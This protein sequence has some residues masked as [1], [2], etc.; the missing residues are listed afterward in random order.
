MRRLSGL[1]IAPEAYERFAAGGHQFLA[2]D[3]IAGPTL[4][5]ECVKRVPALSP[6][7]D[8]GALADYAAWVQRICASVEHAVDLM[9]SRGVIFNDLHVN[10]IIV[11]PG[12]SVAFIDFEAAGDAREKRRLTV[13]APGFVAPADRE[14][15][16]AD[17][18][19]L[20][21]LR[22]SLFIPLTTL[23]TLDPT[24]AAQLGAAIASVYPVP[25]SF[26]AEAVAEITRGAPAPPRDAASVASEFAEAASSQATIGQATATRQA[27]GIPR[28][29]HSGEGPVSL[30]DPADG[31][32]TPAWSRLSA[33][34]I[35]SIRAS[36][37]PERT[38]RLFPGDIGQF[39]TPGGGLGLAYGAAGVLYALDE[40]AGVR[41]PAYE[42]WLLR[43][44]KR[45]PERMPLGCWDG[46]SGIAWAL[47]RLGHRDEAVRLAEIC[48]AEKWEKLSHTL[49]GGIAGFGLA[50]LGVAEAAAEPSLASA[51]L[52]AAEIVA[53]AVL[54]ADESRTFVSPAGAPGNDS[55]SPDAERAGLMRGSAGKALLCVAAYEK[56]ADP[57]FLDAAVTAI[58]A[59][60]R[61][62][63]PDAHGGLQVNE[64]WRIMPYLADGSA[65]IG[66]VIDR[67]LAHRA[68]PELA[69]AAS[70]IEVAASFVFYAY[71]GLFAGRAGLLCFLAGRN[72]SSR[73]V[74]DHVTRLAWHAFPC[75]SGI[76]FPGDQLLRL[77]MDLGTG[78]AGVL[79]G[80]ASALAPGG[81]GVPFLARPQSLPDGNQ[82]HQTP[83]QGVGYNR[84]LV[85]R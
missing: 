13:G 47:G 72:A 52:R 21:C 56:T 60:L 42:E 43:R 36:A 25:E 59:D 76:A 83:V 37:T 6:D 82:Q 69:V 62:C 50:M 30:E 51:G 81:A 26:L 2:E 80:L 31:A 39:R 3:Y 23:L 22:L 29:G 63:V 41:V 45:P 53:D 28:Q 74:R 35:A 20:A 46:L 55:G 57:A 78:S 24:R 73:R 17:S 1:G 75:A 18:Y 14:G 16:A 71:S 5:E 67:L 66:L 58:R 7:P 61:R 54:R 33:D 44:V 48:L 38:D 65:G 12:D 27:A 84:E 77:S 32:V 19:S 8:P 10:N 40:A 9:H 11:R 70:Q 49:F 68:D 64:G 34:L 15:F 79:L 4:R 85:R